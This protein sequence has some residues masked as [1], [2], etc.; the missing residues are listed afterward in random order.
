MLHNVFSR[1]F[2][3]DFLNKDADGRYPSRVT[4]AGVVRRILID[5]VTNV[6]PDVNVS[7]RQTSAESIHWN[8]SGH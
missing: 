7:S 2:H 1:V 5:T 3:V 4:V 8:E 6:P